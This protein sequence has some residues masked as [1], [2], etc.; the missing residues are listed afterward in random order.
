MSVASVPKYAK[1]MTTL[2]LATQGAGLGPRETELAQSLRPPA[3]L[4]FWLYL[5][6]HVIVAPILCFAV[7]FFHELAHAAAV[8]SIGGVVTELSWLPGA[9]N[10]G[11]T[12]WDPPQGVTDL[13]YAFVSVAPY[14]MWSMCAGLVIVASWIPNR[15]HWSVASTLFVWLYAVP[16]GD[17]AG[18]L[19]S[20]HGDLSAPGLEGLVVT[21]AGSVAVLVAWALGF[22]VQRRLFPDARLGPVA[23]ATTTFVMGGA[24]GVAASVGVMAVTL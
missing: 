3:W 2:P 10:L 8:L 1:G 13:D 11:H 22:V 4:R 5:T 16:I 24:W 19:M 21:A 23:Y 17:I 18:N 12:R 9:T 7:T 15:F 14:L 20:S 6:P